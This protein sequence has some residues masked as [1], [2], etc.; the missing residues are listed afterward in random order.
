MPGRSVPVIIII[1]IV[2]IVVIT[3]GKLCLQTTAKEDRFLGSIVHG[4]SK[5]VELF[6]FEI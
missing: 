5:T 6:E 4:G 1:I 3:A 2:V